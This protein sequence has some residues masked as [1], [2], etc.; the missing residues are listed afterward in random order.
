MKFQ[1]QAL[2]CLQIIN[3]T[4]ISKLQEDVPLTTQPQQQKV[5]PID[6]SQVRLLDSQGLMA[7]VSTIAIA[8]KLSQ[9]IAFYNVSLE[10]RMLLE[11]VQL[12]Q[13]CEI[14]E[15]PPTRAEARMAA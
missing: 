15:T 12:D 4:S 5:L 13:L 11:L 8:Q 2:D 14:Y 3:I 6:L 7:I 9:K 1:T 10:V